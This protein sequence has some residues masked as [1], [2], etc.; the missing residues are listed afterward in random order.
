V[1]H[2]ALIAAAL[3]VVLSATGCA[4]GTDGVSLVKSKCGSCH[5]VDWVSGASATTRADWEGTVTR[6]E[7]KGLD[8]TAEERTTILEHLDAEYGAE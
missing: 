5:S 6:M 8:I 4:G 2:F 1:K 3:L 7:A